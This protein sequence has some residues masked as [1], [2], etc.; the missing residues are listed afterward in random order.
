MKETIQMVLAVL[1]I[2]ATVYVL[3]ILGVIL[4][5]GKGE[6]PFPASIPENR[7]E[8]PNPALKMAGQ[9]GCDLYE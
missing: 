9:E 3:L 1:L 7:Y 5:D 4:E 6:L 8:W 2:F